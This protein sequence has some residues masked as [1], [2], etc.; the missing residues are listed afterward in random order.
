MKDKRDLDQI[1]LDLVRLLADDARRPYS[2]LAEHVG[3]SAPA[4]SD[5][6]DRLQ[7]QGV[8]RQ[9]TVDIDRLKLQNRTPV[10]VAFHAHPTNAADLYGEVSE[11]PGIEH[12]FKLYDGTI[13]AYGSVPDDNPSEWLQESIDMKL[14][15]EVDIDL[16]EKYEWSQQLDEAEFSLPCAVCEKTIQTDG[17][18][19]DIGGETVTFCCPS[20]KSAYEERYDRFRANSD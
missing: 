3:L 7:E 18:T 16:V 17:V 6:I 13:V 10:M 2:D 8:I 15:D 12:A 20:C 11:L 14:V 1:D 5:R 19:T 4:V 9:F